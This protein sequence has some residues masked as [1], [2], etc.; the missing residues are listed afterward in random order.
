MRKKG[1]ALRSVLNITIQLQ[2]NEIKQFLAVKEKLTI[3]AKAEVVRKLM[4]ERIAQI[5][6]EEQTA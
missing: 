1:K 3:R 2:G 6:A 5:Q 4:L